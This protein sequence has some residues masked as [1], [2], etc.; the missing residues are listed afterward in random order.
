MILLVDDDISHRGEKATLL[1]RSAVKTH[2]GSGIGSVVL[3]A[4]E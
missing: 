4:G 3:E 2:S 1:N